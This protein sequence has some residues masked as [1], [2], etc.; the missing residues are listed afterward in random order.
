L[1]ALTRAQRTRP[2]LKKGWI[3]SRDAWL[4][5]RLRDPGEA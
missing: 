5:D 2:A 1:A 3:K 4:N